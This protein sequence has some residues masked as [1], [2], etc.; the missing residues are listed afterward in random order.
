M[1]STLQLLAYYLQAS[2]NFVHVIMECLRQYMHVQ[3]ITRP[4][5]ITTYGED[6]LNIPCPARFCQSI[7]DG[8]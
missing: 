8:E 7:K 4:L 6:G 2:Y 3:K 1:P 5:S